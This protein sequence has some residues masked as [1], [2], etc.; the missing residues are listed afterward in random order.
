MIFENAAL[1][2]EN[3]IITITAKFFHTHNYNQNGAS[4]GVVLLNLPDLSCRP[5][6]SQ[7]FGDYKA[8]KRKR[9]SIR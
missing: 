5:L 8:I 9:I 2:L 4:A 6:K 1:L 3:N 7:I